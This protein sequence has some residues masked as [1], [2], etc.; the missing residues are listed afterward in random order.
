MAQSER[1]YENDS[2]IRRQ[3]E[4]VLDLRRTCLEADKTAKD[5]N[6]RAKKEIAKLDALI[7]KGSLINV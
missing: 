1:T 7:R 6:S 5:L 2:A 4:V 3:L